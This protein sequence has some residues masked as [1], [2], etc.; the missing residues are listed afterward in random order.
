[1]KSSDFSFLATRISDSLSLPVLACTREGEIT[2]C[3]SACLE[4]LDV[5]EKQL[6]NFKLHDLIHEIPEFP[7]LFE[8]IL[9]GKRF[10][11]YDSQIGV[12]GRRKID[13]DFLEVSPLIEENFPGAVALF[14]EK[15]QSVVEKF[16]GRGT[17]E[18][19][20][21]E[22]IW[23]GVCHEIKNP[24]GGIKGA[25]QMLKRSLGK[26]PSFET[27]LEI[28]LR[29]VERIDRFLNELTG[30]HITGTR[31]SVNLTHLLREALDLI[32]LHIRETGK[33]IRLEA[34]LDPSIPPLRGDGDALFR[35]FV[36]LLKNAVE[37]IDETGKILVSIKL[38]EDV[39]IRSSTRDKNY[40]VEIE[41]FDTGRK[42]DKED[43]KKI[44]LPFYTSKPEGSGM[45][46]FLVKN[47]IQA[48][49]GFIRVTQKDD[50]KSFAIF[51]PVPVEGGEK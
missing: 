22:I 33:K 21:Y 7:R 15:E 8:E 28:I 1:M 51:L 23:R 42:I 25:A 26:D 27:P 44:F 41:I 2:Y 13:F 38:H 49:G 6:K 47:T 37:A 36:N 34:R 40:L 5:T 48:H 32:S 50:G 19:Q 3:N 16:I 9:K 4:T 46:L 35:A 24:L 31:G 20:Y 39:V 45:G 11:I 43:V 29:E 12:P 14:R 18:E 17:S 30:T 10:V